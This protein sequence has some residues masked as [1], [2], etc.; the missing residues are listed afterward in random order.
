MADAVCGSIF[1]SISR[2][3]PDM[4]QEIKI[5]TYESMSF[6]NDFH[7]SEDKEESF[8]L[9]KVPRMPTELKEAMERMI[10]I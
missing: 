10:I 8:N 2:S 9:I 1:N 5:H 6:D 4:N 3:K 7:P